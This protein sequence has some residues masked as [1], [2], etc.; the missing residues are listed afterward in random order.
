MHKKLLFPICFSL[1]LSSKAYSQDT[2]DAVGDKNQSWY[3]YAS[4]ATAIWSSDYWNEKFRI[5]FDFVYLTR[6]VACHG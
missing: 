3:A 2:S 5:F 1:F 4:Y 6:K